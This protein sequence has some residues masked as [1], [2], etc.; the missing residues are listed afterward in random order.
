MKS[1]L[2]IFAPDEPYEPSIRR[3]HQRRVVTPPIHVLEHLDRAHVGPERARP[4]AHQ[5]ADA[6]IG[7]T[8]ELGLEHAAEYDALFVDDDARVPVRCGPTRDADRVV[9]AA[10]G[11]VGPRDVLEADRA[12]GSAFERQPV[13]AP[14][15][16][17]G[18]VLVDLRESETVEPPRG[19]W[20]QV[21]LKIVAVDDH[22]TI[23]AKR[24]GTLR[25]ELLQRDVDRAG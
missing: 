21:S 25:V 12:R 14:V 7:I 18:R 4:G 8:V 10:G 16:L 3:R 23:P 6:A 20:A 9:D 5:V 19:P 11:D 17:P 24:G 22:R 1:A 13:R 15:G 2:D